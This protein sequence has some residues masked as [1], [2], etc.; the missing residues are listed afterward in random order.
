MMRFL[1]K[2]PSRYFNKSILFCRNLHIDVSPI[3]KQGLLEGKPIVALESTIISHGMP[4]PKNIEVA[5]RI[6]KVITDAGAIPAT[7]AVLN[8]IPTIGLNDHQLESLA[9]RDGQIRKASTRD[10]SYI[11]SRSLHAATTV[12]STMKLASLV[13]IEVFATGGLGG[14]HRD[15]EK[16]MDV[17]ADL[18]ELGKTPVSVVCAGIKSILDIRRS[19][20]FLETQGV[21][22]I[23]YQTGGY[24]PSF[25]SQN[26]DCK[27]PLEVSSALDIASM[28]M[29]QK[30]LKLST[31]MVI[32]VPN[33]NPL[34]ESFIN[35]VIES[36]L[37][38]AERLKIEGSKITPFLLSRI[39]Q[40]SKGKSLESNISLVLHNA[41]IGAEI[42][43][44]LSQLKKEEQKVTGKKERVNEKVII[45]MKPS[46]VSESSPV[47]ETNL[48]SAVNSSH[49][50]HVES[51][52]HSIKTNLISAP[53]S[54]S[55]LFH[56]PSNDVIVIGGATIDLIGNVTSTMT[57]HGT[58]NPGRVTSSFG[59]V[60]RNMSEQLSKLGIQVALTTAVGNDDSGKS[61]LQ[62]CSDLSIDSSSVL[63]HNNEKNDVK[64]SVVQ[65]AHSSSSVKETKTYSTARYSAI[66]DNHGE[67]VIGIA[68]MNI[69]SLLDANYV[70]NHLKEKIINSKVVLCD[71]NVSVDCFVAL[72]TLCESLNK[73]LF[74]EP[75]SD[76]KCLLPFHAKSYQKVEFVVF[77]FLFLPSSSLF[78]L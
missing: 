52:Y 35:N 63:I 26:S 38:E 6:E 62:N 18:V 55:P 46:L 19:L 31:G 69:F 13:G 2:Q 21:P 68:D 7:I 66:H 36:A 8:G 29:T 50:N 17:S 49:N 40:L 42:A 12:A 61:I 59:G 30:Q 14:V 64:K 27:V 44:H 28:I 75:T 20:E 57:I 11:C 5:K 34:E 37:L 16:S 48:S 1:V 58:S 45:D 67:L 54:S 3:V 43:I 47:N 71:G 65:S 74:F 72:S 56:R 73:P 70:N 77:F 10:L 76:H 4:Y 32:G 60:G 39:E 24:F 22:V 78:S 25:F 41:K 51:T 53:S 33:P 9:N 15:V 23:G